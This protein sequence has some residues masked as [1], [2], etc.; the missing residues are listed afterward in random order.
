M[1]KNCPY[2][3]KGGKFND[4]RGKL[5]FFNDFDMSKIKRIYF[6]THHNTKLVRAWQGHKVQ[7]R[8]FCT[9]NG[10]F[11]IKLVKIDNWENPSDKLKVLKYVL[12]ERKPEI[13]FIPNGYVNGFKALEDNSKLLIMSNYHLTK[14]KN[15]EVRYDKN[16]WTLWDD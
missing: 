4:Y 5:D 10:S 3:I 13:L 6:T 8:W 16:K 1:D 2:I 11:I 9:V 12:R 15:E 7:S 14:N